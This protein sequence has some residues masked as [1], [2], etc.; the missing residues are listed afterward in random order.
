MASG[1]FALIVEKY[2]LQMT[3]WVCSKEV[4]R[5]AA[6]HAKARPAVAWDTDAASIGNAATLE[7]YPPG[8]RGVNES[9]RCERRAF[10]VRLTSRAPLRDTLLAAAG[11]NH[12][13]KWRT[14]L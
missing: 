8:C 13:V 2:S 1:Q 3:H 9:R 11:S 5:F 10:R 12:L 6:A 4:N 7:G 14:T